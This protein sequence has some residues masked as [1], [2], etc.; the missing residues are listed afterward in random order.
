MKRIF[1]YYKK[2]CIYLAGLVL[3][4][5]VLAFFR[6][7]NTFAPETFY[8]ASPENRDILGITWMWVPCP[9]FWDT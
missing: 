8:T 4:F 7:G 3:I 9:F 6:L 2:D 1:T 5:S